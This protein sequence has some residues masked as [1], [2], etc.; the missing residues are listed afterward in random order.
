MSDEI[1]VAFIGAGGMAQRHAPSYQRIEQARVVGF[2]D[3]ALDRAKALAQQYDAEAFTD[4]A[5]MLDSLQPDGVYIL[6]PPFVHGEADR[7]A[8]SCGIGAADME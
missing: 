2:C 7:D 8:W 6:L 4:P 1:R 5:A 3:T